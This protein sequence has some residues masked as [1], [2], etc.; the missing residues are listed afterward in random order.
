M[1][2]CCRQSDSNVVVHASCL[3]VALAS[4]GACCIVDSI[5]DPAISPEVSCMWEVHVIFATSSS[6]SW[7]R[8]LDAFAGI[9]GAVSRTATAPVDRLKMLMQIAD[10]GTRLTVRG[11]FRQMSAEGAGLGLRVCGRT[12]SRRPH[13]CLHVPVGLAVCPCASGAQ[14]E[15]C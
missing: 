8:G 6:C 15:Q 1:E 13:T 5:V 11:A 12:V 4:C 2:S 7:T 14:P 3:A 10:S 9:A